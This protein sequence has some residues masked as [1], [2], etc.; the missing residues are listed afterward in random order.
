MCTTIIFF[1]PPKSRPW[2]ERPRSRGFAS[3]FAP[4]LQPDKIASPAPQCS[5]NTA[6]RKS[7]SCTTKQHCSPFSVTAHEERALSVGG[8]HSVAL[9]IHS[10]T[11]VDTVCCGLRCPLKTIVPLISS[12]LLSFSCLS[13]WRPEVEMGVK[14]RWKTNGWQS[15]LQGAVLPRETPAKDFIVGS[16]RQPQQAVRW[17]YCVAGWTRVPLQNGV[18]GRPPLGAALY[19]PR[20][21]SPFQSRRPAEALLHTMETGQHTTKEAL[22]FER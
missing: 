4:A 14:K 11:D 8:G 17:K 20:S 5:S 3:S 15:A 13:R 19:L 1:T 6:E 18:K 10:T 16:S 9:S 21:V 2:E 22:M 7:L 12:V